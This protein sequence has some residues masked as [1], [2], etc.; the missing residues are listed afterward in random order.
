MHHANP[1]SINQQVPQVVSHSTSPEWKEGF[2]WAFDVPPKGQK[3]HILCKSKNTFGKNGHSYI[4]VNISLS[5]S[6]VYTFVSDY[7]VTIQIDKVVGEGMYSGLFSLSQDNNKDGSSQSLE[8][9]IT[10]SSRMPSDMLIK[11]TVLPTEFSPYPG[12][13]PRP[14][15]KGG[16]TPSSAP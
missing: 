10:W 13:N 11:V 14:L 2:T 1:L 4:I 7:R 8:I 16:T 15:I 3:L 12:S 5:I 9:E 6:D